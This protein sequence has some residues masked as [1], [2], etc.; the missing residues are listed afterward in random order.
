MGRALQFVRRDDTAR[1]QEQRPAAAEHENQIRDHVQ[2]PAGA[3]SSLE[4]PAVH[5]EENASLPLYEGDSSFASQ[6]VSA[7]NMVGISPNAASAWSSSQHDSDSNGSY[8][9][10]VPSITAITRPD[11]FF[12]GRGSSR[13]PPRLKLPPADA[14]IQLLR[15]FKTQFSFTL[16]MYMLGDVSRVEQRARDAYFPTNVLTFAQVTAL[17]GLLH[18]LAEG[19][20]L[21][22]GTP[23]QGGFS[24][25]AFSKDCYN[26]FCHGME[27]FEI[28][29]F[30]CAD[31]IQ[32]LELGVST[33][34]SLFE[35]K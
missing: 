10:S 31:T 28:M 12:S 35:V 1:P 18:I 15:T 25:D 22:S 33:L 27:S 24:L 17:N 23:W 3:S 4:A 29:M 13:A 34:R 16:L 5:C 32:A 21:I 30:P 7:S 14:T 20:R 2:D 8:S 11:L 26:N 6:A 9:T 19:L